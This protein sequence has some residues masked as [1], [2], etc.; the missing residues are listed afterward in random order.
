MRKKF[1]FILAMTLLLCGCYRKQEDTPAT[2]LETTAPAIYDTT[3]QLDEDGNIVSPS[4]IVYSF[5]AQEPN[6]YY[7]GERQLAGRAD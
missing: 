7:L 5:L 1:C 2:T 4:G 3:F 6:L